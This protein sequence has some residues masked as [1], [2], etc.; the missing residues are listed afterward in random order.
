M[1][2]S[3]MNERNVEDDTERKRENKDSKSSKGHTNNCEKRAQPNSEDKKNRTIFLPH[4][5]VQLKIR[6]RAAYMKRAAF[7]TANDNKNLNNKREH[8]K[9]TTQS[10]TI[11]NVIVIVNRD[12]CIYTKFSIFFVICLRP[13]RLATMV[14]IL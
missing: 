6:T 13:H 4:K 2:A 10:K 5:K 11:N 3:M 7:Q 1:Y 8:T 12:S 9:M 14:T